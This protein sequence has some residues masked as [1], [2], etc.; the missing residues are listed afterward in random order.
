MYTNTVRMATPRVNFHYASQG[1]FPDGL[2]SHSYNLE[3]ILVTDFLI[4]KPLQHGFQWL[5]KSKT[6]KQLNIKLSK[7]EKGGQ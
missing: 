4:L 2:S 3:V 1:V 6:F 7:K 5:P